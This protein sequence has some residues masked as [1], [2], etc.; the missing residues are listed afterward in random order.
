MGVTD[1]SIMTLP[2]QILLLFF[3]TPGVL[4][5]ESSCDY[6]KPDLICTI[7]NLSDVIGIIAD[8]E[9]EV[10][11]QD[12]CTKIDSCNYFTYATLQDGGSRCLLMKTCSNTRSCVET[13]DCV[14]S[15]SGPSLP[16]ITEA[17]CH[18]FQDN[19][20]CDPKH[21]IEQ[22]FDINSDK[23]CQEVCR[24]TK[25]CSHWTWVGGSL[26]FLYTDCGLPHSCNS[27]ISGPGYP[28]LDHCK[29]TPAVNTLLLGGASETSMEVITS[30]GVCTP[31]LPPI[32]VR[33][34][35][36][37]AVLIH[38][39]LL[40]CGGFGSGIRY[41]RTCHSF[42]LGGG[43]TVWREEPQMVHTRGSFS[44][45]L[46]GDTVYA[47]GGWGD[48]DDTVESCTEK[49][50]WALEGEMSMDRWRIGHCSVVR[51]TAIIILGGYY[52]ARYPS[53]SVKTINT[54]NKTE[55]WK[56]MESMKTGRHGHGC[57]VW[58]FDQTG[59]VI[60]GGSDD[61]G[62]GYLASVEFYSYSQDSWI[63]LG[64][65]V[66]SRAW[67]S[68]T[69]VSGMLVVSGGHHDGSASLTSSLTLTSVEY[70]NGTRSEWEVLTNLK[71][72]RRS[73]SGVSVPAE[74]LDC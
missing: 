33:R 5:L 14:F 1:Y 13:N 30:T 27:C 38:N 18:Q 51:E 63:Q 2:N 61:S 52:E 44:L 62:S 32:P 16:E 74:L 73:H 7:E 71:E 17:C 20:A 8:L 3:L 28:P 19:V 53:R 67:H 9:S 35:D 72:G 22:I 42:H 41:Y 57:I 15:V 25:G 45:S 40:Y 21:Q 69:T 54:T 59:I 60:A 11:C 56:S 36:A 49:R 46:V 70:Y 66:T 37:G 55:G 68:V 24:E 26:C 48:G 4:C 12:E 39:K 65:L 43:E 10:Q 23:E 31:T 50:G 29:E 47:I 34:T 58:T 64:S 6:F